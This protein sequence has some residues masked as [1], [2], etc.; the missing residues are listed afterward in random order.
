MSRIR[1]T[2]VFPGA[3]MLLL[4][5]LSCGSEGGSEPDVAVATVTITPGTVTIA[6]D[7]SVQLQ[8]TTRDV[9]GT[10]LSDREVTWS[11]SDDGVATVSSDG[12]VTGVA[13]GSASI[14]A[15]SEGKSGTAAVEVKVPVSTVVV[16][17][18]QATIAVSESVQL[19]AATLDAD[20]TEL[21]DRAVTWSSSDPDILIVSETGLVTGLADGAATVTATSEGQ[22]GSATITVGMA[23]IEGHWSLE[24]ELDDEALGYSCQNVQDITLNQ[25]TGSTFTGTNVQ[26]GTCTLG[27]ETFDNS[28]TFEIIDGQIVGTAVTFTE[29]GP[30]PCVYE[31]T[32][33]LEGAMDGTVTCQGSVNGTD[34]DVT[35]TWCATMIEPLTTRSAARVIRL[36]RVPSCG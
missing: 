30:V 14:T 33:A 9:D 35:G 11:S 29:P 20:G 19:N 5:L 3:A 36:R 7:A 27:N 28:G 23:S 32:V 22:S 2:V 24:E 26:T 6:P 17:P 13:A 1:F 34:V 8:A 31:G 21:P 10:A 4:P 16:T 25:Q 12:L 18:E 15:T